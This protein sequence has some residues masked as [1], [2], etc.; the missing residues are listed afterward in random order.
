M[1]V[2]IGGESDGIP[3]SGVRERLFVSLA[4]AADLLAT[5]I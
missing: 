2:R 5:T 4:V 3:R 1:N